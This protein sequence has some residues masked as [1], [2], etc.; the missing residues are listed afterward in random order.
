MVKP[1]AE[2][3]WT[4]HAEPF[5][6]AIVLRNFGI[7]SERD[8]KT[9][10]SLY[11]SR[12]D[13]FYNL[14]IPESLNP[15]NFLGRDIEISHQTGSKYNG[16]CMFTTTA[17]GCLDYYT[18]DNVPDDYEAIVDSS[19]R[20]YSFGFSELIKDIYGAGNPGE[21]WFEDDAHQ[22][23]W[24]NCGD[25]GTLCNEVSFCVDSLV[26]QT[27][28]DSRQEEYIA[29]KAAYMVYLNDVVVFSNG[30]GG[31]RERKT[32]I[33][34]EPAPNG[35]NSNKTAAASSYSGNPDVCSQYA[36]DVSHRYDG[37]RLE[38]DSFDICY[39][40]AVR[41]VECRNMFDLL[42][43]SCAF[44]SVDD[45]HVDS[46]GK[47]ALNSSLCVDFYD[48]SNKRR[49]YRFVPDAVGEN[50]NKMEGVARSSKKASTF[51]GGDQIVECRNG[52]N[53]DWTGCASVN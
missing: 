2:G 50:S 53:T 8:M 46:Q 17:G 30:R 5:S 24:F 23:F 11:S 36:I 31:S 21:Y 22:F 3:Q 9:E 42:N 18:I 19:Q 35:C 48:E 29:P 6:F 40:G 28:S 52:C 38:N 37:S 27:D 7:Q 14:N 13:E 43:W 45:D 4:T 26:F 32:F 25:G 44:D 41:H 47:Q 49:S 39:H 34:F 15:D 1:C 10:L 51:L 20:G 33:R 12:A 16:N